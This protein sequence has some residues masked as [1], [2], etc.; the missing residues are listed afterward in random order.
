MFIRIRHTLEYSYDRPVFIEPTTIR[1]TPRQ[2]PTQRTHEHALRVLPE[3]AGATWS[4]EQD[5]SAARECWFTG[6][7]DRL[8]I[9]C[10][11]LVETLRDNPFDAIITHEPA[12]SLPAA[13]PSALVPVLG[14]TLASEKTPAVQDWSEAIAEAS[15]HDTLAFLSN[16]TDRIF[17]EFTMEVREEGNPQSASETLSLRRGACRD[18][19]VLFIDACRAQGLAARFVSGYSIHGPEEI[20]EQELHAWAEVYLPGAGWRGYD[21]SLG[22]AT[23]DG[24]IALVSAPS[25]ELVAPTTGSFRGTGARSGMRYSIRLSTE[26]VARSD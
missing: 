10:S 20:T 21:P 8:L 7:H 19:A 11:S 3:P 15:G 2:D 13:Y 24:H 5:G 18:V 12:S 16:L 25:H 1:L 14:S 26:D 6:E 4:I 17:S 9:E 23:S 22:L